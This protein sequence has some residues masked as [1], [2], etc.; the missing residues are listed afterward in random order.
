MAIQPRKEVLLDT[1]SATTT[2]RGVGVDNAARVSLMVYSTGITAGTLQFTVDV[3]NDPALGWVPYN[4]LNYNIT[5]I[6]TVDTRTSSVVLNTSLSTAI[7]FIPSGDTFNYLRVN[8]N[9]TTNTT[10]R[11][12]A[13]LYVN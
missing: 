8:L 7:V 1:V 10:A 5:G 3:T 2:S 13:V 12:S 6:A 11:G 9:Y 4:R